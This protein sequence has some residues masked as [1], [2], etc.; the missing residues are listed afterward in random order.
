MKLVQI[1]TL[2]SC[3]GNGDEN[4][5]GIPRLDAAAKYIAT[6]VGC[7]VMLIHHPSKVTA[8]TCADTGRSPRPAT[9]SS[10]FRSMRYLECGPLPWSSPPTPPPAYSF[11]TRRNQSSC[12]TQIALEILAPQQRAD[13]RSAR[14]SRTSPSHRRRWR[15]SCAQFKLLNPNLEGFASSVA[16]TAQSNAE[17][18]CAG[19]STQNRFFSPA[20]PRIVRFMRA[21]GLVTRP[22]LRAHGGDRPCARYFAP[23]PPLRRTIAGRRRGRAR[24]SIRV[25][26][27]RTKR[28]RGR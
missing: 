10:P 8:P 14:E 28:E 15:P 16:S 18:E 1:D 19:M 21:N 22:P 27:K 24:P 4:S 20:A 7:A 9:P 26:Q 25:P 23:R 13:R 11:A 5:D 6:N 3:L 17:T 2:A 12:R